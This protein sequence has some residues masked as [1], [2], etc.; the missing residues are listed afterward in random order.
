MERSRKNNCFLL[1]CLSFDLEPFCLKNG[2]NWQ[3]LNEL[4]IKIV[5]YKRSLVFYMKY[6]KKPPKSSSKKI[7]TKKDFY[8][9]ANK[10]ALTAIH[11]K[12][13]F[14]FNIKMFQ[15]NCYSKPHQSCA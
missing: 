8:Q 4:L 12:K 11:I 5:V 10:K 6:S 13:T 9:I 1:C 3:Q 2:E 14:E 15:I 7:N